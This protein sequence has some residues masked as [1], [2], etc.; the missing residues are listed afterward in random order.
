MK[1]KRKP[2]LGWRILLWVVLAGLSAALLLGGYF[3]VKGYRMY[4]EAIAEKPI[5]SIEDDIRQRC[6]YVS[7]YMSYD[8]LP[9]IYIDAVIC[10]ED[11]RF[12][13][14]HGIDYIS[15]CR[16]ILVDIK[17]LSFAEGGST[18]TQQLAKNE[19]FTQKKHLERKFAEIF[20]ARAIE[21]TYTKKE[22]F[23]MYVNSIYFGSGFYSI[24]S[25]SE[26]YF[27]KSPEELSDSEAVMLAGLPNA[28]SLYSP[29]NS[30]YLATRRM[31]TVMQKMINY[32]MI[33][34][35]RADEIMAEAFS[36]HFL[37]PVA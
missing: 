3:G 35:Q 36:I 30:I 20:A 27:G 22:I 2:R 4:K 24:Y 8:E 7:L 1:T 23:E 15:I 14:H 16:A 34:V 28:P 17:T 19:L 10:A 32:D 13:S 11:R 5:E 6:S 12:E 25:A 37:Q 26:G 29:N 21:D 9:Q 18:I 31:T 33:S